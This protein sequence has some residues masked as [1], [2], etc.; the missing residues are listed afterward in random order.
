MAKVSKG[1]E[2]IH[3][4]A[5]RAGVLGV[6]ID[7]CEPARMKRSLAMPRFTARIFT[8]K[9]IAY[10]RSFKTG[11]AARFAARFAAKEAVA[12]S[13]GTGI[14]KGVDFRDIEIVNDRDGAPSVR[15]HGVAK[16]RARE[17]GIRKF[18]CSLTHEEILAEAIVIALG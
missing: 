9:E 11:Q 1:S 8:R 15:L 10:C 2:R 3:Q 6:G 16:S 5:E 4:R 18:I 14:A 17:L 13:L 12:K 7:L